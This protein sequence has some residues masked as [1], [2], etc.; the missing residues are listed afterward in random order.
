MQ[1]LGKYK[2]GNYNVVIFDDGTKIRY[3]DEDF[4]ECD[5]V[6]SMDIKITNMC[7]IGCKMCHENSTPEGK[8]ADLFS[9]SF[10]DTL[11]PYT[12]LAIGGGNPLAHP[13]LEKFLVKCKDK[14]FIPS[15]TVNQVHFEKEFDRIKRL[16]DNKLVYGL[17]VSVVNVTEEL[18]SKLKQITTDV[19]HIINGL[20]TVDYMNKL[21]GNNLKVLMLGYKEFRRGEQLYKS[22]GSLIEEEK[23]KVAHILPRVIEEKWFQVLSFDN[24]A[25]KQLPVRDIIGEEE[26]KTFYMGDDGID[27]SGTSSSIF[28]DMVTRQFAKNSCDPNRYPL[29][30]TV[31]QMYNFLYKENR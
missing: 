10:L 23:T 26:W 29:M 7:D 22:S 4:F 12:E 31:E 1:V 18:I 6:E 14:K 11:H 8:H 16:I 30:N 13:D 3:N 28:I 27:G 21:R 20:N 19:V 15:M 2:N 24:L 5:T 9:D 17:G 25:L